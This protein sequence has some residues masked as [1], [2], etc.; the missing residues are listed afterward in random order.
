MPKRVSYNFLLIKKRVS[1]KLRFNDWKTFEIRDL[2]LLETIFLETVLISI[3]IYNI[4]S[5]Q[6]ISHIKG[7]I[8]HVLATII[9]YTQ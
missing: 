3:S 6:L 7:E 4:Y 9:F 1:Y 2:N 5:T 8:I